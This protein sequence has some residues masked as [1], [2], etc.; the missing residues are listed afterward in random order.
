VID[1]AGHSVAWEKPDEFNAAVLRFL[2]RH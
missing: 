2:H 1:D